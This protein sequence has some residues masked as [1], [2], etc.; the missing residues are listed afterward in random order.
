MS[1]PPTSAPALGGS[2]LHKC[3]T[4][5]MYSAPDLGSVALLPT[6]AVGL[7]QATCSIGG[8]ILV[9]SLGHQCHINFALL[10]QADCCGQA[11]EAGSQCAN[12]RHGTCDLNLPPM[13]HSYHAAWVF[14]TASPAAGLES[15]SMRA[16]GTMLADGAAEAEGHRSPSPCWA[17][18]RI[19]N[20][21]L[22]NSSSPPRPPHPTDAGSRAPQGSFGEGPLNIVF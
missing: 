19:S 21:A 18:Q 13:R 17:A 6:Q 10:L 5:Q 3:K 14:R 12:V 2:P 7:P 20:S 9:E 11:H 15:E 8:G 4:R 1:L 22:C 16:C